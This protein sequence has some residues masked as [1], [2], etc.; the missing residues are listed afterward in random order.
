MA[1]L[2]VEE[3]RLT[4]DAIRY[5][6]AVGKVRVLETRVLDRS[7]YERLLDAPTFTE[8]RR[9]LSETVY[10]RHLEGAETA[11]EVE[12]GLDAALDDFY[13]F[14]DE[15]ALPSAVV[16]FFRVRYDYANLKAALK[17]RVL[18]APLEG[19]I[20]G[21]G[22][23]A[24]EAFSGDLGA[25]PEGLGRL[26]SELEDETSTAVIDA[27]T[28]GAMFAELIRLAK[29]AKSAY[30]SRIA[31]LMVDI[32]N[33]KTMVRGRIAGLSEERIR[34][35]LVPGGGVSVG[36]LVG[37]LDEPLSELGAALKAH[38]AFF[39]LGT[40]DLSDASQLDVVTDAVLIAAL[41]DGRRGPTGPEP[42]I[43]YVFARENEVASLRVLLLGR[44]NGIP[45]EV[46]R[47][48]LRASYR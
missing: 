9:L 7:A 25:L 18:D 10:G 48:R 29:Q 31:A 37:M 35:L 33:V 44:I 12:R 30:L 11:D 19:L 28:D 26:A 32:G 21:H 27:R 43:A 5:G 13:G 14:I 22:M 40:T 24:P 3:A 46:L 47:A 1:I 15:A 4:S 38:A 34:A 45:N 6:F 39:R 42:V 36:D 17:A 23:V 2:P 41:K 20:V 8:Q 16:E